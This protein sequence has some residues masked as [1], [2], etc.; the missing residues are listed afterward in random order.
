MST[1]VTIDGIRC[2]LERLSDGSIRVT[3][4]SQQVNAMHGTGTAG[5]E[6][7]IVHPA[8][9]NQY[10]FVNNLL[11]ADQQIAPPEP[12]DSRPWWSFAGAAR[13]K[14]EKDAE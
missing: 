3:H 1:Q 5:V 13:E 12:S 8:Q 9:R 6:S 10:D 11:P 4:E 14:R 7:Y 2:S